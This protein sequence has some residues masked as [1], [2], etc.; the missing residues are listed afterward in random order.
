MKDWSA[1]FL[2]SVLDAAPEG[3]VICEAEGDQPVVY[4]NAAFEYLTGHA[5]ADLLGR[6]L[7]HLQGNDREQDARYRLQQA[8]ERGDSCQVLLRNYRKNGGVFWVDIHLQP[9]RDG[10]GRVTHFIGYHRDASDRPRNTTHALAGLPS[11]MREDR[12]TSL[13]TR[14]YFEE[15]LKRDWAL[16]QRE[17]RQLG[18]AIF[19]I[20]NL[21]AYNDT[22]GRAGGDAC[23]RRTASLIAASFR[24]G[25]DLLG[26]WDGGG[27]AVLAHGASDDK[28]AGYSRALAQRVRD[29]QVHH[30]RAQAKFVTVSVGVAGCLPMRDQPVTYLVNAAEAALRQAK[31][32]G[33]NRVAIAA[34]GDYPA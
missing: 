5:A 11:W 32:Q 2:R 8:I 30:P 20:D 24:R 19:D 29:Q 1:D 31:A 3:I 21:G 16:A 28:L 15:L 25:S 10:A 33:R 18:L 12:L 7:R 13:S 4:V 9:V 23:I 27:I 14:P 26:R 6:N 17:M 34:K 22:Y